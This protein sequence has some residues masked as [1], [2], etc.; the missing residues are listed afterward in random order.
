MEENPVTAFLREA[1]AFLSTW[2][3]RLAATAAAIAAVLAGDPSTALAVMTFLPDGPAKAVVIGA[4]M[5]VV[6]GLP[7]IAIRKDGK[8]DTPE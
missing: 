6:Y 3:G 5:L 4:L 2:S 1:R 8:D 7:L